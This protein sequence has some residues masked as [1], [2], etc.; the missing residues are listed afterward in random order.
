MLL[1]LKIPSYD[2]SGISKKCSFA[3]YPKIQP[4]LRQV[5]C[6]MQA[7]IQV[8]LKVDGLLQ[9]YHFRC[10][11]YKCITAFQNGLGQLRDICSFEDIL[12]PWKTLYIQIISKILETVPRD[13]TY[14]LNVLSE[15]SIHFAQFQIVLT[16]KN[17][18]EH[19]WL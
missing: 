16:K 14:I 3:T 1:C 4:K 2:L 15:S 17:V 5:E 7:I 9:C 13:L 18:E 11:L 12:F 10:N 8:P 19:L 6:Q